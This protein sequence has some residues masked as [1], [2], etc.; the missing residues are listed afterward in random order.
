[1]IGQRARRYIFALFL[2]GMVVSLWFNYRSY[3]RHAL[4]HEWKHYAYNWFVGGVVQGAYELGYEG[5]SLKDPHVAAATIGEAAMALEQMAAYQDITSAGTTPEM[6]DQYSFQSPPHVEDVEHYLS[7]AAAIIANPNQAFN[8]GDV[9]DAK[10]YDI[11]ITK[12]LFTEVAGKGKGLSDIPDSKAS[13][14]FTQMYNL[15]PKSIRSQYPG[16]VQRFTL[17]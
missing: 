12:L 14:V 5:T 7:Y 2:I 16:P 11:E 15:I 17:P 8:T 13:E 4:V 1:M 6:R 3:R 10:K 9:A